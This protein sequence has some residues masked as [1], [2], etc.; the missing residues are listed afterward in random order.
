MEP[1]DLKGP[2]GAALMETAALLAERYRNGDPRR[3]G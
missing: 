3:R 1:P 2:A